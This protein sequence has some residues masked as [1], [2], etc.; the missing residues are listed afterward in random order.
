MRVKSFF[1]MP[2][3]INY[4]LTNMFLYFLLLPTLTLSI[5]P[6]GY[7]EKT[8]VVLGNFKGLVNDINEQFLHRMRTILIQKVANIF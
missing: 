6:L 3:R 1:E 2:N 8:V 4:F 7:G 5:E